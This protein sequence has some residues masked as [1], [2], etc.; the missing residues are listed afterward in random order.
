[1]ESKNFVLE[2]INGVQKGQT[3][4]LEA[5]KVTIGRKIAPKERKRDWILIEDP[6]LARIHAFLEWD[7]E[8]RLYKAIL[9]ATNKNLIINGESVNE[10]YLYHSDKLQLADVIFRIWDG[11][12]DKSFIEEDNTIQK[13]EPVFERSNS[14]DINIPENIQDIKIKSLVREVD[15]FELKDNK[16]TSVENIKERTRTFGNSTENKERTRTLGNSANEVSEV[17]PF[18]FFNKSGEKTQDE[19]PLKKDRKPKVFGNVNPEEKK[20]ESEFKPISLTSNSV[21]ESS[22]V[23]QSISSNESKFNSEFKPISLTSSPFASQNSSNNVKVN[24]ISDRK[25]SSFEEKPLPKREERFPRV[26]SRED[27]IE[28]LAEKKFQEEQEEQNFDQINQPSVIPQ[29]MDIKIPK[30]LEADSQSQVSSKVPQRFLVENRFMSALTSAEPS[31]IGIIRARGRDRRQKNESKEELIENKSEEQVQIKKTPSFDDTES[32]PFE[33]MVNNKSFTVN[34]QNNNFIDDVSKQDEKPLNIKPGSFFEENNARNSIMSNYQKFVSSSNVS[35][36]DLALQQRRLANFNSKHKSSSKV[37]EKLQL[38]IPSKK[39]EEEKSTVENKQPVKS[40]Q[41]TLNN[42][43]K[44]NQPIAEPK[45]LLNIEAGTNPVSEVFPNSESLPFAKEEDKSLNISI[46]GDRIKPNQQ[47]ENSFILPFS[48]KEVEKEEGF[49]KSPFFIDDSNSKNINNSN[50]IFDSSR[51]SNNNDFNIGNEKS[52]KNI[53]ENDPFSVTKKREEK[54]T[55]D[56]SERPSGLLEPSDFSESSLISNSSTEELENI[57]PVKLQSTPIAESQEND[58]ANKNFVDT[59][60]PLVIYSNNQSEGL[61]IDSTDVESNSNF[62]SSSKE[63]KP[64]FDP[65]SSLIV[66]SSENKKVES[67]IKQPK[68]PPVVDLPERQKVEPEFKQPLSPFDIDPVADK[69]NSEIKQPVSPFSVDLTE[70]PIFEP[71]FKQPLTPA[72]IESLENKINSE[73]KQA[74][75]PFSV[76]LIDNKIKEPA[77]KQPIIP[78]LPFEE[79][80]SD[81]PQPIVA[82]NNPNNDKHKKFSKMRFSGADI[83][84]K[85]ILSSAG[86]TNAVDSDMKTSD[87]DMEKFLEMIEQNRGES[88]NSPRFESDS[89]EKKSK[90]NFFGPASS[91]DLSFSDYKMK[92]KQDKADAKNKKSNSKSADKKKE[93]IKEEPKKPK[94]LVTSVSLPP[95]KDL[96]ST[97]KKE[98][99]DES[100]KKEKTKKSSSAFA[101]EELFVEQKEEPKKEEKK[102]SSYYDD[103]DYQSSSNK[104]A[105]SADE[106]IVTEKSVLSM[107]LENKEKPL[108][109]N[110]DDEEEFSMDWTIKF[111]KMPGMGMKDTFDLDRDEIIIGRGSSCDLSLKDMTLADRHVKLYMLEGELYLQKLDRKKQIFI[112]GNPLISSA[113]RVL[114]VGDRIQLSD[115]TVFEIQKK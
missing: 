56:K 7:P 99:K 42:F 101:F 103:Y 93:E 21:R 85:P 38:N 55:F 86:F 52:S 27:R 96:I 80:K 73:M 57:I 23:K 71:E 31:E 102:T 48:K 44:I 5:D 69:I 67:E 97:D 107:F 28:A 95:L 61:M 83:V 64:A 74:K 58:L 113:S 100:K 43:N 46:F 9:K 11:K 10:G 106:E 60:S 19:S 2:V 41:P 4:D 35:Y 70:K 98:E 72:N 51:N 6:S 89:K 13:S 53:P 114:K 37:P 30:E 40:E 8:K 25:F 90:S 54:V 62:F 29:D 17:K 112:N 20:E 105:S 115:M 34:K 84:Q 108:E 75:S 76:D 33:A 94:K 91:I 79:V 50:S 3:F 78:S 88:Q 68:I 18:S 92:E 59:V 66:D 14:R 16:R 104:K 81:I 87:A 111:V 39:N 22:F 36:P 82:E 26:R 24:E 63:K 15:N 65:F 32:E 110:S 49:I 77:I 1:M 12:P 45:P 47:K 109:E